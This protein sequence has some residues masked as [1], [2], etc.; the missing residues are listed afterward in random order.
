MLPT[1]NG[2][3]LAIIATVEVQPNHYVVRDHDGPQV[4]YVYFAD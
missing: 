1:L 3:Q 2:H 4:A